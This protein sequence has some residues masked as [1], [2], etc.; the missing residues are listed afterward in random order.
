MPKQDKARGL[1]DACVPGLLCLHAQCGCAATSGERGT[2]LVSWPSRAS[3]ARAVGVPVLARQVIRYPLDLHQL[4]AASFSTL[5]L[6][7]IL[8]HPRSPLVW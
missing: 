6:L 8:I 1:L 4:S 3:S 2:G 5:P 7:A